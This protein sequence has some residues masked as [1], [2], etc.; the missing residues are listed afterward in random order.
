MDLTEATWTDVSEL[1][2]DLAVLPVGST[3]QHGPHAPLGTDVLTARAVADAGVERVDREVVRA[4]AIPVGIAEEHRQFPGTMWV[5]P[6]TFR[7]YVRESIESLAYHGFDRVVVVNGHGGNVDALREVGGRLSR[8]GTA[9]AVPFTWFEAVGDHSAEMGH[10][11]PL[12]T[13]LVRH[14][15]PD[16]VREDRI[17][18]AKAGAADGWGEWVSHANLAYDSAEFTE[19]GVVGDPSDGTERR[20]E[21]LLELAGDALARLLEAVAERNVPRP[22]DR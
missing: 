16:L 5:S 15:E 11:G 3:E 19:N 20:G 1:E 14:C 18:E 7:R 13:A 4:P 9:Y 12:E 6:E 21:E 17:D 8:D 22:D 10:G 2:T